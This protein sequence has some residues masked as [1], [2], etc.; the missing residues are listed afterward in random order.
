MAA[1]NTG[2]VLDEFSIMETAHPWYLFRPI[3]PKKGEKRTL[4]LLSGAD[5]SC[6]P[7]STPPV[8]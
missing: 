8:P 5:R 3:L 7:Y 2:V 4:H 1:A 6:D